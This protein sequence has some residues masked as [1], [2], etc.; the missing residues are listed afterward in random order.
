MVADGV[1]KK[2]KKKTRCPRN[3]RKRV[4]GERAKPLRA[5]QKKKKKTVRPSSPFPRL[6]PPLLLLS[7]YQFSVGN[8]SPGE[9]L[10]LTA[11]SSSTSSCLSLHPMLPAAD[12]A[13]L[14]LL[15]PAIG[16]APLARH[17]L[18]A[19]C[20]GVF[21]A[22]PPSSACALPTARIRETRG[23][24]SAMRAGVMVAARGPPGRDGEEPLFSPSLP[25]GWYLPV[26]RP[27]A[28]GV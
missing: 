9:I 23:A 7:L 26:S 27:C 19:T 6:Q 15:T 3:N 11:S 8:P 25:S 28:S 24:T 20:A 2:K 4:C 12:A 17:Q 16:S 21:G 13:C 14:A 5:D 18:S 22:A 10:E 1:G